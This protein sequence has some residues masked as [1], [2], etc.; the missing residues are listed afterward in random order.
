MKAVQ[1]TTT[2]IVEYN[3]LTR[4]MISPPY[5]EFVVQRRYNDFLWL[6]EQLSICCPGCI[7]PALPEKKRCHVAI[8]SLPQCSN[9]LFNRI[10]RF[11]K[12]FLDHRKRALERFLIRIASHPQLVYHPVLVAFLESDDHALANVR[13]QYKDDKK[14]SWLDKFM[15]MS[16]GNKV[17]W[18]CGA[19]CY[20]SSSCAIK[21]ISFPIV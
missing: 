20:F 21:T 13:D 5:T 6:S 16:S 10:G 17:C 14:T 2:L 18:N 15:L 19:Y 7:I 1:S 8:N 3:T 9:L 11:N 12:S 4:V